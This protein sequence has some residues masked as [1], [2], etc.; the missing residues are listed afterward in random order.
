MWDR[1]RSSPGTQ[2]SENR[3]QSFPR[4]PCTVTSHGSPHLATLTLSGH[5]GPRS[6]V[7]S[8]VARRDSWSR[9]GTCQTLDRTDPAATDRGHARANGIFSGA[10]AVPSILPNMHA[11]SVQ[12]TKHVNQIAKF[13]W[14]VCDGGNGHTS[15]IS[16]QAPQLVARLRTARQ[17]ITDRR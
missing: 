14:S 12:S 13:G 3:C 1:C 9:H 2:R 16:G 6:T 15:N 10:N 11:T 7:R 5:N 17:V 4:L 8:T